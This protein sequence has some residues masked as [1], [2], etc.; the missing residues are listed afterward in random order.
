M[1][2]YFVKNGV[3]IFGIFMESID[4]VEDRD[5][6]LNFF[7]NF[8]IFYFLG[9]VV[10][11]LEDVV[12]VV[13]KIGYFVLV[14][15]FYV[16]GGRVMEIV[17]SCD[18]FEKYIKVVIEI[19]IKYFILIDKY[20]FGKEVEVDGILDGEDVLI[21]GIMEYI[22]RVGVYFGDSMV[23]FFFYILF[24]KV[25][26]KIVDYIIKFVCVLKVVGF[27]NI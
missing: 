19:L 18:E 6:F 1:V 9:G 11:S 23:V 26:E 3:K 16:F 2:L 17:Y 27:F 13:E 7:K 24:E 5:K 20:I 10:Y 4:I 15:L 12:R 25:K 8:N 22:E 21:F 14:R